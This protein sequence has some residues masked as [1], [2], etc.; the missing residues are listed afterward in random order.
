[1]ENTLQHLATLCDTDATLLH[2]YKCEMDPDDWKETPLQI[3][4][5][6]VNYILKRRFVCQSKLDYTPKLIQSNV[7]SEHEIAMQINNARILKKML[8]AFPCTPNDV[9]VY[10]GVLATD[11]YFIKSRMLS[12]GDQITTPY[13]LS[14]SLDQHVAYRFSNNNATNE[15]KCLWKILIPKTFPFTFIGGG[16]NEVLINIG[17]T[18]ECINKCRDN[19]EIHLKLV[20]FSKFVET[21]NFWKGFET[22]I[23]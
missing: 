8:E 13:F 23:L 12:I 18:F 1:M 10:R 9:V 16:E 3:N 21:R 22:P 2:H 20:G 15:N 11:F 17:A 5:E 19:K 14:T 7:I 4:Y 6:V